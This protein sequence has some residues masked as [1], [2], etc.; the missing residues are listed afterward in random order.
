MQQPP[1]DL[2]G[3]PPPSS[4]ESLAS[5]HEGRDVEQR[6]REREREGQEWNG[7]E[8]DGARGENALFWWKSLAGETK[9][10]MRFHHRLRG[11]LNNQ[12]Q[13]QKQ[14][15]EEEDVHLRPPLSRVGVCLSRGIE[16]AFK[17]RWGGGLQQR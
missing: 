12:S 11:W 3:C 8:H 14:K 5:L 13:K 7:S 16:G 9:N 2:F 15:K 10:S 1:P 4:S 17:E 6:E